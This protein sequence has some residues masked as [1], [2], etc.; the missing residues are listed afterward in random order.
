MFLSEFIP[1]FLYEWLCEGECI[2]FV[3]V[4]LSSLSLFAITLQ[5]SKTGM[6]YYSLATV[7]SLCY[8]LN[9]H[10]VHT[11]SASLTLGLRPHVGSWERGR[12]KCLTK[13][14]DKNICQPIIVLFEIRIKNTSHNI[15]LISHFYVLK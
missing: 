3:L 9:T 6:L 8:K 5:T 13:I 4:C 12:L 2:W 11:V 7:S 14:T 1:I 15:K 10:T